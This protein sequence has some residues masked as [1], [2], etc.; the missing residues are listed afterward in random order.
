M[1]RHQE[2]EARGLMLPNAQKSAT[3]LWLLVFGGCVVWELETAFNIYISG[4][5]EIFDEANDFFQFV[6]S[7]QVRD[8]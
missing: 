2:L 7:D 4:L 5:H 1:R 8:R 6:S 3:R